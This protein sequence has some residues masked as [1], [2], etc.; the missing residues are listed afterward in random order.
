MR[1]KLS[2][3]WVFYKYSG[4]SPWEPLQEATITLSLWTWATCLRTDLL[5]HPVCHS[6]SF[7]KEN[8][9]TLWLHFKWSWVGLS[10]VIKLLFFTSPKWSASYYLLDKGRHHIQWTW[11]HKYLAW[12]SQN[13]CKS[14]LKWCF[15]D[16]FIRENY[17]FF[18][19]IWNLV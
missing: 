17:V 12:S 9:L 8:K 16:E 1:D 4:D 14:S 10:K 7:F 19:Q 13:P 15:D 2:S 6:S 5:G 3:V 11:V 18:R